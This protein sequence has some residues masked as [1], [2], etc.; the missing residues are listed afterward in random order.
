MTTARFTFNR[1]VTALREQIQLEE[2]R[3]ASMPGATGTYFGQ[4]GV[5]FKSLQFRSETT[6]LSISPNVTPSENTDVGCCATPAE[7]IPT[8]SCN[9]MPLLV[10]SI[11]F[12]VVV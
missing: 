6:V 4:Y 11:P 8:Y 5:H 7:L 10:A 12:S 3:C 2:E 1:F 9:A